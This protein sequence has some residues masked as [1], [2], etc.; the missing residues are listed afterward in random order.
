MDLC[1]SVYLPGINLGIWYGVLIGNHIDTELIFAGRWKRDLMLFRKSKDDSRCLAMSLFPASNEYLRYAQSITRTER[2][3]ATPNIELV[4][5]FFEFW[6]WIVLD[7][8][9]KK[10]HG[11]AEALLIAYWG[12]KYGEKIPNF[13]KD[14]RVAQYWEKNT[15]E[16]EEDEADTENLKINE[17]L[18]EGS[19]DQTQIHTT[20]SESSVEPI[21]ASNSIKV[22]YQSIEADPGS[23]SGH[24]DTFQGE[25]AV[26]C[27][28]ADKMSSTSKLDGKSNQGHKVKVKFW[29]AAR[30]EVGQQIFSCSEAVVNALLAKSISQVIPS[31]NHCYFVISHVIILVP[32]CIHERCIKCYITL[33]YILVCTEI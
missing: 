25:Q 4:S 22:P 10:D 3:K 29:R 13:A 5:H 23:C 28:D 8:R 11:R 6:A 32:A 9:R 7:C 12:T 16:T 20:S 27:N 15:L 2:S 1:D 26:T 24:E 14:A 19:T 17:G 18:T 21:E 31:R 30:V 33:V